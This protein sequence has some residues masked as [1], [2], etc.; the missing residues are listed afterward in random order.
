MVRAKMKVD[1][2]IHDH[3]SY[4]MVV[5]EEK[6]K[7]NGYTVLVFAQEESGNKI[8]Y[9]QHSISLSFVYSKEIGSE[10]RKFWEA[11]PQGS[12]KMDIVNETALAFFEVGKE[13]YVDFTA[14]E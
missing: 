1:R 14:T 12:L 3:V 13:Y 2:I 4:Q 11:T 10:N 7:E 5:D 6:T 8:P 9:M